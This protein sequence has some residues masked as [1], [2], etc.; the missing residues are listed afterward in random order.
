[1]VVPGSYSVINHS[2][3][4][5]TGEELSKGNFGADPEAE[6]NQDSCPWVFLGMVIY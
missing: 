5:I 2:L 3:C 4:R 1:M 6:F